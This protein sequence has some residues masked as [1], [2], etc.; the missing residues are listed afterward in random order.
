MGL[1]DVKVTLLL[2]PEHHNVADR[3]FRALFNALKYFGLW[4]GQYPYDT[5]TA[6][7]PPRN[8]LTCCMEYP[9][10]I[11][12]ETSFWPPAHGLSPEA[13]TFHEFGHQYWFGLVGSNESEESWLDEGLNTY[14]EGK[15]IDTIHGPGCSYTHVF[16]IP[17]MSHP[18]LE[19]HLPRFPFSGVGSLGMGPYFFCVHEPERTAGREFY[20]ENVKDD[21]LARNGWQYVSELSY[22]LN[23]YTRMGLTLRTLESYLGEETMIRAIRAYQQ[24]W[25][26]RHPSTQD[27]I[28]T[29]N[30]VSGRNMDWFFQQFYQGSNQV[31]YAV[32]EINSVPLDGKVGIFEEGGK[33]I[34]HPEEAAEEAFQK[35]KDKRY[36]SV[37]TVRRLGE[38]VAPVD[39]LVAFDNGEMAREQWDGQYRWIKYE[40]EKPGRVKWAQVD[41]E[42]KLAL[43]VNFTNNSYVVKEDNSGA[44]KWYVHWIFWLE[45]LFFAAGFF[46]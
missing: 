42:G 23:S 10:F 38:A 11:T 29:V 40:Y 35:S 44:S 7:D 36:R 46:T 32:T 13:V 33:R 3:Y 17:L 6:V 43:D 37:V 15:L 18:W 41:P 28:D 4:Y 9:T 27:F 19:L 34:F 24:R 20:I 22:T 39:V 5:L 31:D 14:S 16:G 12:L 2:Q 1:R 8:S 26:Y 21:N 25:R 30:E 45:N